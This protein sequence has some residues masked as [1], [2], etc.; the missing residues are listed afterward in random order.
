[1]FH[2]LL[3]LGIHVTASTIRRSQVDFEI[4]IHGNPIVPFDECLI[5]MHN[6]L[7]SADLVKN[8]SK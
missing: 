4:I 1:M 2:R 7:R 5:E 6:R 3:K 8:K